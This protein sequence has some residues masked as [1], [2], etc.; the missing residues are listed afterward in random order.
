M[1]ALSMVYHCCSHKESKQSIVVQHYCDDFNK[2]VK[3][4]DLPAP[5]RLPPN[6]RDA[7][8]VRNLVMMTI[9]AALTGTRTPLAHPAD[10]QA[11][12]SIIGNPGMDWEDIARHV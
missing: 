11:P 3:Q 1:V 6:L 8:G 10:T 7:Y 2:L 9:K 5:Y 12:H 4:Y